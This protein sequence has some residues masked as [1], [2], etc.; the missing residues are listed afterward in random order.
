LFEYGTTNKLIAN[1]G[2]VPDWKGGYYERFQFIIIFDF[3]DFEHNK[4]FSPKQVRTK[5]QTSQSIR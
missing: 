3:F 4:W 2:L 5:I 1:L